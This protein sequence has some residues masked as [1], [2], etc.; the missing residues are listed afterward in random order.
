MF[1]K[2]KRKKSNYYFDSFPSIYLKAVECMEDTYAFLASFNH[3]G[4]GEN[5]KRIHEKEHQGDVLKAEVWEKLTAE[6]MTPIEREDI[7]GLLTRIDDVTDAIEEVS[8]RLYIYDYRELPLD[9][10]PYA[11]LALECVKAT[12]EVL[13]SFPSF[14]DKEIMGPLIKK[15]RELEEKGD[16]VYEEKMRRL[17]LETDE[18]KPEDGFKRHKGEAMYNML[19]EIMDRCKIT[20]NFVETIMF[21][22]L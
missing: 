11:S 2:G 6:F 21:K 8:L 18:A 20:A 15:V 17:Y 22:N 5:K 16:L 19:E 4:L 13:D 10:L 3:E 7:M 12:K 1:G 9:T 14:M